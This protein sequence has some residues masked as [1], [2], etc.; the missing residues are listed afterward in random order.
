MALRAHA[1]TVQ[2]ADAT[3]LHGVALTVEPGE[4]VGILGP[5]GA[6]KSTLLRAIS[7]EE[8]PTDGAVTYD[9]QNLYSLSVPQMARVRALVP[10][11]AVT[12][13]NFTVRDILELG[14][15]PQEAANAN[16]FVA[17]IAEQ[18][19]LQNLLGR[20]TANLSG[21]ENQRVRIGR[22]MIQLQTTKARYILLDEPTS[23]QDPGRATLLA[24]LLK[25][26]AKQQNV[27][28][29]VIV[30]DLNLAA[31]LCDRLL[32]LKNGRM[33]A[34]GTANQVFT[35]AILTEAFGQGLE[36]YHKQGYPP[37]VLPALTTA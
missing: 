10:Q 5:N 1:I 7:G 30:H 26:F 29:L 22:A 31:Q 20:P 23:A 2:K 12:P 4:V 17:N 28:V 15:D 6:G 13:F 37:I 21:G 27:G 18:L 34:E 16:Q 9:E 14:V 35:P 36:V 8:K 24:E 33:I 3:L 25:R 32:L 19:D 11:S